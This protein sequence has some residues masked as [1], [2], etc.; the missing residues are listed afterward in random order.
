MPGGSYESH[1]SGA[2]LDPMRAAL[3]TPQPIRKRNSQEFDEI[4]A[5]KKSKSEDLDGSARTASPAAGPSSGRRRSLDTDS[6]PAQKRK[7]TTKTQD[8]LK[9]IKRA[10][11][12]I[13]LAKK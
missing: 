8:R 11:K 10:E 13:K 4:P 6:V 2:H 7:K 12:I 9:M 5:R 1:M 3:C